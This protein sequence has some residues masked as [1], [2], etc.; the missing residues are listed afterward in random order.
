[1]TV[2]TKGHPAGTV[3]HRQAAGSRA[4]RTDGASVDPH[5]TSWLWLLGPA[6]AAALF[7]ALWAWSRAGETPASLEMPAARSAGTT[8]DAEAQRR[9]GIEV[10]K[11]RWIERIDR[12]DTAG[13]VALNERHTARIGAIVEGVVE[14]VM[15]QVGDRVK[16]GTL[17]A[18]IHSHI[19]HDAWAAYFKALAERRRFEN[20]VRYATVAE[21]RATRLLADRALSPQELDRTRSDRI[22]AEQGL[23]SAK[24]EETR[25]IQEL[26]HYGITA[27]EAGNPREEDSVP[28]TTP[29]AG[30]VIERQ[31]SNGTAVTPGTPVFVVS[32]LS[33]V[34]VTAEVDEALVGAV[35]A[36]GPVDV[37]VTAYPGEVFQGVI[38][39]VGDVVNPATRRVTVRCEVPNRDGRL[40]PNMFARVLLNAPKPRRVLV[41]PARAIQEM[42]G[43]T[44]VFARSV[45]TQFQRRPVVTGATVDG[46][47]EII[48][49]A[50]DDDDI[51]TS[52]AFLIKSELMQ[53]QAE[54]SGPR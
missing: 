22:A 31:I 29:F 42:E 50:D 37:Q 48:S 26:A 52:G 40:K 6:V 21:A 27:R 43:E 2:L 51:A 24:A 10:A 39:A 47:T 14:H 15:V 25:A 41:L 16:A 53:S 20:E 35:A 11:P 49:G 38:A 7:L 54:D 8:L 12:I 30:A 3:E 23:T 4:P 1:V 36:G 32:D 28:V 19:V 17:L 34:W 33:S 18:T 46:L 5:R 13:L 45:G 9:S 44:V